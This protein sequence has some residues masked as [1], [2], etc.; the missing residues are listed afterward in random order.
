MSYIVAYVQFEEDDRSL[1]Y[2]V[3]CL[4]TDLKPGDVVVVRMQTKGGTLKAARVTKIDY[5]N[6]N[7]ANTIECLASEAA[8]GPHEIELP[9]GCPIVFGLARI[10]DACVHLEKTGWTPRRPN[11]K[12][13]RIAYGFENASEAAL[14][15]F[16][17]NGVDMQILKG[18][19]VSPPM[20]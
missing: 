10:G 11:N 17:N 8:L 2:P 12:T 5:L 4:R 14:I 16:R 18:R 7:C 9:S 19:G 1:D 15:F 20:R 6:W 13:F 3:N